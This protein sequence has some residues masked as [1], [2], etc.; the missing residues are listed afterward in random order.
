[1]AIGGRRI[2]KWHS[3]V[4]GVRNHKDRLAERLAERFGL[5]ALLCCLLKTAENTK[6]GRDPWRG[7]EPERPPTTN[8]PTSAFN[9]FKILVLLTQCQGRATSDIRNPYH[10]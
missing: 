7:L 1:M 8:Q 2:G 10:S 3:I 9:V 4:H 5:A 6:K